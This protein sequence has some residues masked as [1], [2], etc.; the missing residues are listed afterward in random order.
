MSFY[1]IIRNDPIADFLQV[2]SRLFP[3][4]RGL[5]H[6]YWA[7]NFWALYAGIDR[8]AGF[9]IRKACAL[10]WLCGIPVMEGNSADGKVG[11]VHFAVLP[12]ISS[13]QTMV[14]I[15]AVYAVGRNAKKE[16]KT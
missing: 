9:V 2:L 13:M 11:L 3:F 4:Q 7:P 6:A 16:S 15:A 12:E 1:P 10:G 5:L 14:L 8:V